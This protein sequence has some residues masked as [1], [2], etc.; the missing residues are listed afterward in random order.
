MSSRNGGTARPRYIAALLPRSRLCGFVLVLF[1]VN[2][3]ISRPTTTPPDMGRRSPGLRRYGRL[4]EVPADGSAADR[5]AHQTLRRD[6]SGRTGAREGSLHRMP[7]LGARHRAEM[8]AAVRAGVS[9]AT[10][11]AIEP[12]RW[13]TGS[14]TGCRSSFANGSE[15]SPGFASDVLTQCGRCIS[16]RRNGSELADAY[17]RNEKLPFS[18]A[19][20]F[21]RKNAGALTRGKD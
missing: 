7:G 1:T 3:P 12:H 16:V 4:P 20:H 8:V 6:L 11:V 17:G 15:P 18:I 21:L 2:D 9:A 5:R 19:G 13:N 10:G 14:P